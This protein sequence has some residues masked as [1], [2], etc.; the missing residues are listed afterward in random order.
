MLVRHWNFIKKMNGMKYLLEASELVKK[1]HGLE[2]ET[3]ALDRVHIQVKPEEFIAVMGPS[4]CGKSTLLHIL[5]LL[6][7]PDSGNYLF[8]GQPAFPAP[9]KAREKLIRQGIGFVFQKFNLVDDL[10]IFD[11]VQLPLFYQNLS[12]R[13][14]KIRVNEVLD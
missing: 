6:D 10:S 9:D 4:G 12:F 13:Q 8:N 1:Y 7:R 2:I 5:G 11:N 3:R 14:R